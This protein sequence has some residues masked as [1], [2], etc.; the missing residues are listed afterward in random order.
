MNRSS[1][2]A[3]LILMF[4]VCSTTG[5]GGGGGGSN[6][7]TPPPVTGTA[8]GLWTGTTSSGRA[9]TGLVLDDGTYWVLYSLVGN[10]AQLAG[11]AQGTG[12][13]QSGSLNSSNGKDFNFE[14]AGVS[15]FKLDA[16]YVQKQSVNA[17][18]TYTSSGTVITLPGSYNSNYDLAPSL[19]AITG[20]YS[21]YAVTIAGAESATATVASSGAVTG[22]LASGC[23]FSGSASSRPKGNVYNLSVTFAGAPC[24]NGANTG[25]GI[26]YLDPATNVLYGAALNGARTSGFL[27]V[28]TKTV[29][30]SAS[31]IGAFSA[32][33]FASEKLAFEQDE[34]AIDND[35][36]ARGL[37][38]SGT[39][40]VEYKSN[41]LGH[42]Q[43]SFNRQVTEIIALSG[44]QGL[45]RAIVIPLVTKMGDDWNAY[46]LDKTTTHLGTFASSS[47]LDSTKTELTAGIVQTRDAAISQLDAAIAWLN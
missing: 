3:F 5:C 33:I 37:Y 46:M 35:L 17:R 32:N 28:G 27:F 23:N 20:N 34:S 12:T 39:H 36:A 6:A 40:I 7:T 8:E 44:Q 31:I 43:T 25:N 15:D 9:A 18:L 29:D 26:G 22:R 24:A 4:V 13:Y 21:G 38:Q 42:V 19:S 41:I 11:A 14:G 45:R 16:T 30:Q 47:L 1:H 10:A 2:F